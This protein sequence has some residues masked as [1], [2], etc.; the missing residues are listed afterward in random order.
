MIGSV[1]C[2]CSEMMYGWAA[3]GKTKFYGPNLVGVLLMAEA[4]ICANVC[5]ILYF[6]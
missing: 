1:Y 4:V 5:F 6:L 2:S 3:D